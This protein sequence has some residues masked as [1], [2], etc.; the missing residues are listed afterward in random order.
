MDDSSMVHVH[1]TGGTENIITEERIVILA[2]HKA[3]QTH[4]THLI[5]TFR[6]VQTVLHPDLAI[7][8]YRPSCSIHTLKGKAAFPIH[9]QH[10]LPEL[11]ASNS[12]CYPYKKPFQGSGSS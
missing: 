9:V 3:D 1:D 7:E 4:I 12:Q 10:A 8:L 5:N 6:Q 2:R 11:S